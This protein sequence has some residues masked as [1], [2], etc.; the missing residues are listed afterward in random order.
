MSSHQ[1]NCVSRHRVLRICQVGARSARWGGLL[2]AVFALTLPPGSVHAQERMQANAA[3]PAAV[4]G[5]AP[6]QPSPI[7]AVTPAPSQ[8]TPAPLPA[9]VAADPAQKWA[10]CDVRAPKKS[11]KEVGYINPDSLFESSTYSFAA[12][13]PST[14]TTVYFAGQIP[15][16]TQY[17]V[18]GKTL[19]EQLHVVLKNLC[20]AM[21]D[22]G[23]TTADV[24]KIGVTYVHKDAADPFVLAEELAEFFERDEMPVTTMM[25]AP[26]LVVDTIRVQV[27]ATAFVRGGTKKKR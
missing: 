15:V 1:T 20:L 24:F 13:V 17:A 18:Q 26:F 22:A 11:S 9:P 10:F 5:P 12:S 2:A 8:N 19:V 6:A 3:K 23:V 7:P 21:R 14:G 4:A 27:E 25:T 16:D